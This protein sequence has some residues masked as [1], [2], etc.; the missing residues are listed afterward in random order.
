MDPAVVALVVLWIVVV[1][2]WL[3][4]LID[5]ARQPKAVFAK[6][7]RNKAGW[8]FRVAF[9]G[10]I[11]GVVYLLSVRPQLRKAARRVPPGARREPSFPA[12]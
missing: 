10:W 8:V 1:P 4:S 3:F 9:F 7:G 6:I 5:V 12:A 11:A 2:V